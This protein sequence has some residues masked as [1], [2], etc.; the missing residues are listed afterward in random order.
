MLDRITAPT[1]QQLEKIELIQAQKQ[2]L[3][4]GIPA[5]T[6]HAGTQEVIKIEFIFNAG[7]WFETKPLLS[8]TTNA[9]LNAGTNRLSSEQLADHIDYYG[10]YL[11]LDS[12]FDHGIVAVYT[13]NKHLNHVL[14]YIEELIKGAVFP[15]NELH[16]HL[17]NSKQR[18]QVSEEKVAD[19]CRKRFREL[20]Y[21]QRHPY[22]LYPKIEDYNNITRNDL[23]EFY[24]KYH[25]AG[26]CTIIASGKIPEKF[27]SLLNKHFGGNDWEKPMNTVNVLHEEEHKIITQELVLKENA[28]QSAIRIGFKLFNKTHPDYHAMQVLNTLLGGYFGSRLMKNIREDKGYTYGINSV[29]ASFKH[30]G[31]FFISTE[32][33]VN[34]CQATIDEAKK[35]IEMLKKYLVPEQELQLVKNYMTGMF[36]KGIDGPFALADRF[37][38]ILFYDLD[39]E[40]Y[41]KYLNTIKT[42]TPNKIQELA[43]QYFII[44][45]ITE[46]VVG[47]K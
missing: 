10:A 5:Y 43:Q 28:L 20:L 34:V 4:N 11:E 9:L 12:D 30:S 3:N 38:S 2:E 7:S 15:E 45:T 17:Q 46:L 33:G 16:I 47:K 26:N 23:L 42:I 14:P 32:V 36:L 44:N 37:K 22:G 1:L 21:G 18:L 41:N 8:D 24:N 40:Y 13:L 19:V 27:I 35:E 39:Y 25:H 29:I 6:I 31:Y